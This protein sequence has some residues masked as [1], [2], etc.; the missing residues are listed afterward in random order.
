MC[1][2]D[3]AGHLPKG[4]EVPATGFRFFSGKLVT[5]MGF[6]ADAEGQKGSWCGD[7]NQTLLMLWNA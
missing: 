4:S 2:T 3:F 6:G 1:S 5:Q 7:L